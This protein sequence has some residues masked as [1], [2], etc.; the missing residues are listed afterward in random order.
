[1]RSCCRY[2]LAGK[3]VWKDCQ[4][5]DLRTPAQLLDAAH[6]LI[7]EAG[8]IARVCSESQHVAV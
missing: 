8:V 5:H 3:P 6:G 1:M 4:Y 7:L 2:R